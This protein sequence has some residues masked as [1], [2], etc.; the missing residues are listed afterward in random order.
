M[1]DDNW[2]TDHTAP[3]ETDSAGNVNNVLRP[4]DIQKTSSQNSSKAMSEPLNKTASSDL[5][6]AFPET[7][8]AQEMSVNPLPATAGIGNPVNLQAGDKVPDPSSFTGNTI[9]SHVTTDKAS[10]ENSSGAPQLPDVVTPQQERGTGL[11]GLPETTN[12]MIPESS[13]PMGS[14]RP[15]EENDTGPTIRSAGAGTTTA[16]L[17]GKVPLEPRGVPEIVQESQKEA[18]IDPEASANKEMVSEKSAMEKE[19]ESK[20]PE[21]PVTSEGTSTGQTNTSDGTT[22]KGT[23]HKDEAIAGGV[24]AGV[25]G[26]GAAAATATGLKSDKSETPKNIPSSVQDSINDMNT[27]G[28]AIAPTVPDVVQESITEAHQ[29]PE[30]AGSKEM[31]KE[32]SA[33]EAQLL[34]KVKTEERAGEPAPALSAALSETAPSAT[35]EAKNDAT[36]AGEVV[37]GGAMA[38]ATMAD[39]GSKDKA[40]VPTDPTSN[41]KSTEEPLNAPARKSAMASAMQQPRMDSRDVS[42]MTRVPDQGTESQAQPMVTTGVG[43]SKAPEISQPT[44]NMATETPSKAPAKNT[45]M[46]AKSVESSTSAGASSKK[47][48]RSS[49]FFGKLKEKFSDRKHKKEE[50]TT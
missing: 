39:T 31:V 18:K 49:G 36:P 11:F 1:V 4:E 44:E 6:G 37:T 5:P 42:P 27:S 43:S 45:P 26:A 10:Y 33:M 7:P 17:A 3:Q 20:V 41:S 25:A 50:G 23:S 16:E 14:G 28:T 40:A 13:L 34:D 48:K 29:A 32:K 15:T 12:N 8:A 24:L 22:T 46:S 2:T 35:G 47:S 9:D 19:L 38:G 21:E 30:A